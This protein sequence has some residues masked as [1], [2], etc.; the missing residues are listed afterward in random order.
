VENE[1][2]S[3]GQSAEEDSREGHSKSA[4]P[5]ERVNDVYMSVQGLVDQRGA[6]ETPPPQLPECFPSFITSYEVGCENT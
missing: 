1:E 4:A 2:S 6:A 5:N 3:S